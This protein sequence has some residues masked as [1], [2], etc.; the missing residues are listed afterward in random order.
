M[1]QKFTF[2]SSK[3]QRQNELPSELDEEIVRNI[4]IL[5][6]LMYY[7]SV[8]KLIVL[9]QVTFQKIVVALNFCPSPCLCK[10]SFQRGKS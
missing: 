6:I 2:L 7:F 5:N 4:S 3:F 10:E 8:T 1:D 9:S